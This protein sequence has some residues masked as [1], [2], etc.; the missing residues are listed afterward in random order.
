MAGSRLRK[1]MVASA[2]VAAALA[3]LTLP[4]V[5]GSATAAT[6]NPGTLIVLPTSATAGSTGDLFTAAYAAPAGGAAGTVTI[7]VPAGFSVP[8]QTSP[9][10]A[11]YLSTISDCAQ[12]RVTGIAPGA[13]GA[14]TVTLAVKCAAKRGGLVIYQDVTAP[15]TA[16][17]YPVAT[18]FTPAG[19]QTP[20]PFPAQYSVT[21]KPGP[22]ARLALT[23]A[24]ATTALGGTQSYTAQGLDAFGNSR[25]DVTAAT[26]FTIAPDGS[27]AG[28]TCTA[29]APGAHTVTGTDGKASGTAALTVSAPPQADLAA[30]ATVSDAAPDYGT[31][32]TFTTTVTNNSAT[33]TSAGV[34]VA[35][36]APAALQSPSVTTA[37]GSYA[38]GTW[39]IGSL[40]PGASA[41]LTI[42]GMTGNV[43]D[44]TQTVTATATATTRDPNPAN[45][46]ASASEAT[47]PAPVGMFYIADPNNPQFID[48]TQP[49]TA[50]WTGIEYN[51]ANANLWPAGT[52]TW[53]CST[54]SGNPCPAPEAVE[55]EGTF[56]SAITY[57]M[58]DFSV[59]TYTLT[60]TVS[61]TDPNYAMPGGATSTSI[62]ITFT[63]V[64]NGG[65]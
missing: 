61:W 24:T 48:I 34:T 52:F 37:T 42:T 30:T 16:G 25:G 26:T 46:T 49:G 10:G 39:T 60:L 4:L 22:L 50:K 36:A 21:V 14:S 57:T 32:V 53:T 1:I 40:A 38:G 20:V 41:T 28:A 7:T 54:A 35:V 19:G 58:T 55:A 65:S 8:Q 11:G 43:A 12:F 17:A 59:D 18:A 51:A 62:S 3:G 6:V 33:T 47:Q 2:A 5:A 64:N 9:R 13:G 15:A 45:N 56:G 44:G 31:S 29:T 27:C 23:P 63:T